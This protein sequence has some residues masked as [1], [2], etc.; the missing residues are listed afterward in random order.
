MM[1]R[2]KKI[3]KL[4]IR[5]SIIIIHCEC[6][7]YSQNLPMKENDLVYLKQLIQDT[8][9]F[10]EWNRSE[11]GMPYDG[12]PRHHS[13]TSV[14]NIGFYLAAVAIAQE[15]HLV[16]ES[17]AHLLI[18]QTLE[19]LKQLKTRSGFQQSW[20]HVKTL[21]PNPD[22]P[23]ISTLDSGN[24]AAGLILVHQMMPKFRDPIAKILDQMRWDQ[25][26]DQE[27]KHFYGG[28]KLSTG[29]MNPDWHLELLGADSRLS[30]IIG[31]GSGRIPENSWNQL[32]RTQ[33]QLYGQSYFT[34]GW[35]GGGLF[36][37]YISG[38]FM[39]ETQTK[40]GESAAQFAYAQMLHGKLLDFPVWGWSASVD[41]R[42]GYL[43]WNQIKDEVITPHA[44]S[45]AIH[46]FPDQV[47]S[48]LKALDRL[49]LRKPVS[50]NQEIFHFGFSDSIDVKDGKISPDRLVLDQ[51]M[52]FFSLVNYVYEGLIWKNF[53]SHPW[54]QNALEII[55]D[56]HSKKDLNLFQSG[57]IGLK[58]LKNESAIQL[59]IINDNPHPILHTKIKYLISEIPSYQT[60][61]EGEKWIDVNKD[62]L[63]KIVLSLILEPFPNNR[64][65]YVYCE[66]FDENENLLQKTG[67]I[68]DF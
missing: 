59:H 48:N 46:Y 55:S 14:T 5:L 17:N 9:N 36:M 41:P 50:I 56:Y 7:I 29:E 34:P 2:S 22:D 16:T 30:Y 3:L 68:L 32:I 42:G 61:F 35:Q 38:L 6:F 12:Y 15:I 10:I 33:E 54:I 49:G 66:W 47:I 8:W 13:M 24:L 57:Y 65:Y 60:I 21:D 53:E 39:N 20:N 26:F 4:I 1:K 18:E 67:E 62:Q 19:S 44:S 43:G 63:K 37:Q 45:L 31:I 25:L 23:W 11:K 51:C 58:I 27:K 40:L 64:S 28:M 52:L